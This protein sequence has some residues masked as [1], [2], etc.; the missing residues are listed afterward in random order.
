MSKPVYF[1][2]T[3]HGCACEGFIRLGTTPKNGDNPSSVTIEAI[4]AGDELHYRGDWTSE[5]AELYD[6]WESF[7]E[8][9]YERREEIAYEEAV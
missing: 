7:E 8:M 5:L 1:H 6:S 9:A 2:T 3:I 4:H